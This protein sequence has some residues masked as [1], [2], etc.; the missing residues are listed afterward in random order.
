MYPRSF[1][2]LC[3]GAPFVCVPD[4][5][6]GKKE[7]GS[8]GYRTRGF[9]VTGVDILPVLRKECP[10]NTSTLFSDLC[11]EGG[12]RVRVSFI[13]HDPVGWVKNRDVFPSPILTTFRW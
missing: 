12:V 11:F 3:I 7:V 1:G 5:G 4:F 13:I 9:R 8:L 2:V 6:T 10:D